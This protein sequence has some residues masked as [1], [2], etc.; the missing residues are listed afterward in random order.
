VRIVYFVNQYPVLNQPVYEDEAKVLLRMGHQVWIVPVWGQLA[1]LDGAPEELKERVL[2]MGQAGS[3]S[4]Y[5]LALWFLLRSPRR[6]LACIRRAL[7]LVGFVQTLRILSLSNGLKELGVERIHAHFANA[8]ALVG[9]LS[10]EALDIP[11]SCTGHGTEILLKRGSFLPLLIERARPFIT[12]SDYNVRR[13]KS[14]V[15]AAKLAEIKVIRCGLDLNCF[16]APPARGNIDSIPVILCVSWFREVKGLT[17]LIDACGRLRDRGHAF[18][19]VIVGGG[20]DREQM[21]RKI[22]ELQLETFMR[23]TGPLKRPEVLD[24]Y[25]RSDI[26]VL[27]SLSEG[28]PL[29]LMEAMAMELPVVATRITGIP[30]LVTEGVDGLLTEPEDGAALSDVLETLLTDDEIRHKLGNAARKKVELEFNLDVSVKRLLDMFGAEA[31][32]N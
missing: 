18:E 24:W 26:F 20:D 15:E 6:Q 17:Y 2:Q 14:E 13:L 12:I 31:A 23:L 3:L 28:I 21:E 16:S 27:P 7:P 30:E 29:V 32:P 11:F 22:S 10:A 19:C 4:T 1:P 25:R 9:L 8:A 5:L